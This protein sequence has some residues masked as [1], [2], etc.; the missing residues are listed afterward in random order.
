VYSLLQNNYE[1]IK[2][3]LDDYNSS[4]QENNDGDNEDDNIQP[5]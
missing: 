4:E 1:Q 2:G 3:V 5:S